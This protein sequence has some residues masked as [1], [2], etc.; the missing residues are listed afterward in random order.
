[1][2]KVAEVLGMS[3]MRVYEVATFYTMFNR[4]PIGKYHIE[5]CTITPCMLCG[6]QQILDTV[7]NK[8]GIDIGE[9]TDDG[10]FTLSEAECLAACV[11][12][13]MM[14]IGDDYYEDL[15]PELTEEIIDLFAKGQRPKPGP[16]GRFAVEPH[17]RLTLLTEPPTDPGFGVRDDL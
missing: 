9:T 16:R 13:P 4:N 8:L 2:H 14:M 17:G 5:V 12:A 1:M 6:S 10:M 11:N 15:T 7:R 3:R